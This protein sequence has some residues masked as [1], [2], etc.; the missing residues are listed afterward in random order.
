MIAASL[1]GAIALL[2]PAPE[3]L[4]PQERPYSAVASGPVSNQPRTLS[5]QD[6][7]L[8]RQGLAAAR[9]RDVNGAR[10]AASQISD[11]TA[12]KL[13]EWALLDTS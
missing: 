1:A 4:V 6:T 8:F 7:A 13:V 5:D 11:P 3:S 2:A 10:S 9:N 12:R